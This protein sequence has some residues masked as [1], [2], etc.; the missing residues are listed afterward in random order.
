[1]CVKVQEICNIIKENFGNIIIVTFNYFLNNFMICKVKNKWFKD[2]LNNFY[3]IF[4]KMF[5]FNKL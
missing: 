4:F 2:C 3:N 5:V 1:M